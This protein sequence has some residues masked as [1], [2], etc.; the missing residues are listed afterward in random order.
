MD[1]ITVCNNHNV[2]VYEILK[3]IF[4]RENYICIKYLL[5]IL[6]SCRTL[7][8]ICEDNELWRFVLVSIFKC[9]YK[10]RP[11]SI[12]T[13]PRNPCS[14]GGN[15]WIRDKYLTLNYP[16]NSD[17]KNE[18]TEKTNKYYLDIYGIEPPNDLNYI[19]A[20]RYRT[21]QG[22]IL[23]EMWYK[24]DIKCPHIHHY[25]ISTLD[26]SIRYTK[27]NYSDYKKIVYKELLKQ[28]RKHKPNHNTLVIRE[29]KKYDAL[30]DSIKKQKEKLDNLNEIGEL[31]NNRGILEAYIGE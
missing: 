6:C 8:V 5:N 17:F 26:C 31:A 23:T 15:T 18:L 11:D 22:K 20:Y 9:N 28:M 19:T 3:N 21:T 29:Q 12:H 1:L 16:E 7:K 24:L 13:K 30:L 4:K 14:C 10:I 2:F 27:K 25:D